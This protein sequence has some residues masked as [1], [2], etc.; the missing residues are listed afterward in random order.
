LNVKRKKV[1][2][3]T[4]VEHAKK[5]SKYKGF[6]KRKK[7]L[8]GMVVR[9]NWTDQR[10]NEKRWPTRETGTGN[11]RETRK[12]PQK[13]GQEKESQEKSQEV[14]QQPRGKTRERLA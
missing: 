7:V 11:G 8:E 5:K 10:R 3:P 12:S 4:I 1:R 14:I 9:P 6:R 2:V 13:G